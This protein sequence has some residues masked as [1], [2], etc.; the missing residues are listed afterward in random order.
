MGDGAAAW[1]ALKE[2]FD[3]NIKQA[4]RTAREKLFKSTMAETDDP[5]DFF[6][7]TDRLR[8]RLKEMGETISD[9]VYESLLL[10]ACLLYT[11]PSPR[12]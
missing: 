9:E 8:D 7:N 10:D 5:E 11:S 2:R 1:K 3:G 12:D 6:S 4:R